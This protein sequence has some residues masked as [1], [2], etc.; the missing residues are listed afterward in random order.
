MFGFGDPN[1]YQ[2]RA[3]AN[4]RL[5]KALA[6]SHD[7]EDQAQRTNLYEAL[8][9]SVLLV[10]TCDSQ[11]KTVLLV[12]DEKG[13]PAVC[14]FTDLSALQRWTP[15]GQSFLSVPTPQLLREG[16][17]TTAAG[18]WINIADRASRFV[19]RAELAR[20]T[21]GLVLPTY[22]TQVERDLAPAH[23][24]FEP[25][26]PGTLPT[27]LVGRVI[28]AIAREADVTQAFVLELEAAPKPARLCL[29]LRLARVLDDAAVDALLR[30]VARSINQDASRRRAIDV[31]VLDFKRYRIAA[32][33]MPPIWERV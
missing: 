32:G 9:N 8:L 2:P 14:T 28:E 16:F 31:L 21:G 6:T 5:L 30:R 12:E 20:V 29:G 26:S 4:P 1:I 15:T 3:P 17:P 24:D 25:R 23:A 11:R 18:L 22:V 19:S 33:V 13:Q 10:P 7:S 27:L